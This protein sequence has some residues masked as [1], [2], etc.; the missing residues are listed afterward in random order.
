MKLF[1]NLFDS[2]VSLVKNFD[3]EDSKSTSIQVR[4]LESSFEGRSTSSTKDV[5][6]P[7]SK[8]TTATEEEEAV[9]PN[10]TVVPPLASKDPEK[11]LKKKKKR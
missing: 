7:T 5:N 2:N 9:P 4:T 1:N 10:T 8:D 3:E 6:H 11:V